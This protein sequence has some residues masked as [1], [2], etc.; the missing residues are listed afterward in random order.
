[1]TKKEREENQKLRKERRQK[2]EGEER[3]WQSSESGR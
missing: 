1:M 3:V 2:R